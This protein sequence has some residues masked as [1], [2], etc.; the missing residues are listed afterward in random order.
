MVEI[1]NEHRAGLVEISTGDE[2]AT[3]MKPRKYQPC[4]QGIPLSIFNAA[5]D[6]VLLAPALN[7]A[8]PPTQFVR[9]LSCCSCRLD[10]QD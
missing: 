8:L 4:S 10:R 9:P 1:Q 2:Q 7:F 6:A 3:A 5:Y